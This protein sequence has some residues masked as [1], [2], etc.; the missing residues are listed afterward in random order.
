L[1]SSVQNDTQL[2]AKTTNEAAIFRTDMGMAA[3]F[4]KDENLQVYTYG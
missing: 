2:T 3:D 4:G 1:T